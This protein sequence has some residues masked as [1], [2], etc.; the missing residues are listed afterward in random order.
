MLL[1]IFKHIFISIWTENLQNILN[2][3]P[4]AE[5]NNKQHNSKVQMAPL[6]AAK[7]KI[8]NKVITYTG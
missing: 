6:N 3:D 8:N 4:K 7:V 1:Y 2:N 5:V